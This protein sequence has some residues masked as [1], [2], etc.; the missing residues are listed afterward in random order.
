MNWLNRKI[1][2]TIYHRPMCL[3]MS[4][5]AYPWLNLCVRHQFRH[6]TKRRAHEKYGGLHCISPLPLMW[7]RCDGWWLFSTLSFATDGCWPGASWLPGPGSLSAW[8]K[9]SSSILTRWL[10]TR[11]GGRAVLNTANSS[12]KAGALRRTQ[13]A[14]CAGE[15]QVIV[16]CDA[17]PGGQTWGWTLCGCFDNLG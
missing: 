7:T 14:L 15:T 3:Q 17:R 9:L 1:P 12:I 5:F 16:C 6:P 13:R 8:G 10:I 11:S 2:V 4:Y